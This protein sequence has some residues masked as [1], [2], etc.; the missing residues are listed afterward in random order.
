MMGPTGDWFGC[1]F[2]FL[3]QERPREMNQNQDKTAALLEMD[4]TLNI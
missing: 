2:T 3:K 1:E 4:L